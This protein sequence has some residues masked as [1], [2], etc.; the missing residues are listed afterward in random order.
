[1][2]EVKSVELV[3]ENLE[4]IEVKR[5]HIGMFHVSNLKRS[6]SRNA[7]NS[8]SDYVTAEEVFI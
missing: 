6:I 5:E 4:S 8:I 7:I 2:K 3:L 1:M